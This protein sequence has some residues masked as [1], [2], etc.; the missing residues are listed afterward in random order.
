[1]DFL[2]IS[3]NI[4]SVKDLFIMQANGS[5]MWEEMSLSSSF[6]MLSYPGVL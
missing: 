4:P 1:M 5:A 2:N 3:G 6:D